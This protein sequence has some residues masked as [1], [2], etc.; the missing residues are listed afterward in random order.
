MAESHAPSHFRAGGGSTGWLK[1]PIAL[2][3]D[4]DPRNGLRQQRSACRRG[5]YGMAE[6]H[7]PSHFR[8]GGW[9]TGWLKSPI[10]LKRDEDPRNGLPAA[11]K[12]LSARLFRHG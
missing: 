4:E 6:S 12:R 3:R 7:A 8:A 9:S 1:S 2:K 10:A 11:R 5:F